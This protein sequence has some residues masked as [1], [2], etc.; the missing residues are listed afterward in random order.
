MFAYLISLATVQPGSS[1]SPSISITT[2]ACIARFYYIGLSI[3]G[4]GD[5]DDAE[6]H[7]IGIGGGGGGCGDGDREMG[8]AWVAWHGAVVVVAAALTR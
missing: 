8:R 2:H 5:G 4:G 7:C 3:Q 1:L 6:T